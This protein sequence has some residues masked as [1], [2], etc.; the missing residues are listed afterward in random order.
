M[1]HLFGRIFGILLLIIPCFDGH[2]PLTRSTIITNQAVFTTGWFPH[3]HSNFP[4]LFLFPVE[5]LPRTREKRHELDQVMSKL[6]GL[7]AQMTSL[8]H[9]VALLYRSLWSSDPFDPLGPGSHHH[10]HYYYPVNQY[11]L[12]HIPVPNQ[13]TSGPRPRAPSDTVETKPANGKWSDN[14]PDQLTFDL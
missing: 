11:F 14:F 4:Q 10:H 6:S 7:E 1:I 2:F 12:P 8:E 3:H 9:S 5:N 13:P